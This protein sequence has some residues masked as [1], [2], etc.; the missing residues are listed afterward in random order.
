MNLQMKKAY[1]FIE[2]YG[3][4]PRENYIDRQNSESLAVWRQTVAEQYYPYIRP[5][6]S[7]TKSQ[8]RWWSV[9]NDKGTGLRFEGLQPLECQTLEYT[10]H[11]LQ[12]TREKRQFHS[13]DL[14]A[15]P[16]NDVH[17]SARSMGI[18]CVNSW[19]ALPRREYQMLWQDYSYT[20]IISPVRS[21]M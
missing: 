6:E 11:D 4:G 1:S 15:E 13:G 8:V 12:P 19:G 21:K 17:I 10:E 7:G 16:F 18:G 14:I 20:F 2:Y 5:Q 3:K 9:L